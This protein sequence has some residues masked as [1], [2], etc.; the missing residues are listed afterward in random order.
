MVK[1]EED[2]TVQRKLIL[3]DTGIGMTPEE[4]KSNLGTLAKSGTSEFLAN[5]DGEN[6]SNLIGQFGVGYA[7]F[8]IHMESLT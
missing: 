1:D 2:E 8:T 3:S 6:A 5:A 4:L 7:E